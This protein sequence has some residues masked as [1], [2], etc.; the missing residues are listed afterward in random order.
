MSGVKMWRDEETLKYLYHQKEYTIEEVADKMGT[1]QQVVL[2]WMDKFGVNRR[3]QKESQILRHKKNKSPW[4]DK[5]LVRKLYWDEMMTQKEIADELGCSPDTI[6]KWMK[7]NDIEIRDVGGS[8]KDSL[9]RDEDWLREN[10]ID[11]EKTVEEMAEEVD[12]SRTAIT[13]WMDEYGIKRRLKSGNREYA[14]PRDGETLEEMYEKLGT[15]E[16]MAKELG[17]DRRAVEK[18]MDE[19]GLGK[20][21]GS[22]HIDGKVTTFIDSG[23][24]EKIY[25]HQKDSKRGMC[26]SMHRIVAIGKYGL[27]SV[28]GMDIHHKNE[29]PWDNRPS[30]LEPKTPEDHSRHH[31]VLLEYPGGCK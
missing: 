13:H 11:L 26:L 27:E 10:Y 19:E 14:V 20:I 15:T 29:V 8:E 18:V 7:R 31:G 4:K 23:G 22:G 25:F 16:E 21:G 30:N 2:K 17:V 24:Y 3:S 1:V 28:D 12:V 6:R 9:Y 5:E